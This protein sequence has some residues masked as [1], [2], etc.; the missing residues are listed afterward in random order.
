LRPDVSDDPNTCPCVPLSDLQ[1]G[2]PRCLTYE[3]G[4]GCQRLRGGLGGLRAEDEQGRGGDGG[5]R[6][7]QWNSR[8]R[9]GALTRHPSPVETGAPRGGNPDI[10][11]SR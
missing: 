5:E 9:S 6:C 3:T 11:L 1:R 2:Q 4:R 10:E 7:E 8:M